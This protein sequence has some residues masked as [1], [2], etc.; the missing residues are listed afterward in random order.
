MSNTRAQRLIA[1]AEG[2]DAVVIMN[3]GEPFLD[4]TFWYLSEQPG[5]CFESSFAIVRGDR[6][7]VV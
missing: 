5:G 6:K 4:S 2:M 7:S 1:N 3:D